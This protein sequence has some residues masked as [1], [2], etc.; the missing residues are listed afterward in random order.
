MPSDDDGVCFPAS[1]TVERA[2]GTVVAMDQ[3]RTGDRVRVSASEFS[4]VFLWTHHN[5]RHHSDRYIRLRPEG[6]RPLTA[7]IVHL[8]PVCKGAQRECVREIVQI[9]E[10]GVGDGVWVVDGGE[11]RIAKI[12]SR[13]RIEGQGL[14]NPQTMHGDVVVDGVVSTSKYIPAQI[15]HSLLMPVRAFYDMVSALAG[16][17]IEFY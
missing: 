8:V 1:A 12:V 5:A 13:D 16:K 2:D 7:T 4:E 14:Y 17:K 3:L 9:E 6:G 10:I 15:A 11:E